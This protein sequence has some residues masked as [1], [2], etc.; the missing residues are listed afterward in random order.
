M[1]RSERG[2][3]VVEVMMSM[4]LLAIGVSG[5]IALQKVTTTSNRHARNVAVA[6][7]IVRAWQEQLA[8]DAARWT[9]PSPRQPIANLGNT[10]WLGDVTT[11]AD[12]W[13]RPT[14]DSTRNFG[15]A[16]DALGNP[17]PDAQAAAAAYCVHIRLHQLRS[18]TLPTVGNGAI[19]ADVRVFWL[20]DGQ[21]PVGTDPLCSINQAQPASAAAVGAAPNRY[22][23]VQATTAVRQNA[24]F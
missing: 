20:R 1:R 2:Y 5:V 6:T 4:T 10:T 23:F 7:Q 21:R 12:A 14:Y 8:V 19:R 18:D 24:A 15:A 3:T 22:H 13:F 16:F 9:G 11:T 17:I